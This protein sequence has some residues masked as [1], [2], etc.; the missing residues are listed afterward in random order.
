[1]DSLALC[2]NMTRVSKWDQYYEKVIEMVKIPVGDKKL[3]GISQ[4]I[5]D[6]DN[7]GKST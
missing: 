7:I 6:S 1:M 2:P 4:A 5:N 3:K